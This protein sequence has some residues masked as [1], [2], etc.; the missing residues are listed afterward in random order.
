MQPIPQRR[1]NLAL[2]LAQWHQRVS[3]RLM[4]DNHRAPIITL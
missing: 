4:R 1:R 3:R 2:A